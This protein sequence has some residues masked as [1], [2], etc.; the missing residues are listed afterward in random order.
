MPVSL[1]IAD[2]HRIILEGLEQLFQR[3][4]DFK[5]L[6]TCT[7]GDEAL[8]AVRD[9]RPDILVLDY[10]MPG[11][12][13]LSVLQQSRDEFLPTRVVLLTAAM[14]EDEVLR[15]VK[16]GA[17]GLVLKESAAVLLVDCVRRVSKGER[18]LDQTLM[19]KAIDR[20]FEKETALKQ[21]TEILSPRETEIVR[22]VA[23]GMR[24]KEIATRLFIGEGTVKTHLHAIY[25][26][27]GVHGR[28]ELTVYARE[29]GLV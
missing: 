7:T 5:V 13:G 25:R 18:M 6:G 26:K 21:T 16:L 8:V 10:H 4:K 19:V 17:S 9:K 12:D 3:E 14:D 22:M 20:M 28:V 2:D 15:A 27:L 24:N 1:V 11:R 29:R 23:V